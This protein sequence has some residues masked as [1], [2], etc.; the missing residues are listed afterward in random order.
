MRRFPLSDALVKPVGSRDLV[1]A[2]RHPRKAAVAAWIGSALEY[3][4]FFVYGTV[5]ALVFPRLFFPAGNPTAALF[6]SLAT[7]G[8]AYVARPLGSFLMGH[9]GDGV[10]RKKVMIWTMLLMGVA[11]FLVGCLPSYAVIGLWAPG[12]LVTLRILQGLSAAGEQAGANSMSFEHAPFGRR[13]YYTSWT[14]SGTFGGQVLAPAVVL[15]LVAVLSEDQLLT[16]GWR[17]P[18]WISA[19]IVVVGLMLRR[20]L[21]E[22]P[23][24]EEEARRGSVPRAPL[25]ELFRGHTPTVVKVF[26]AALISS[27]GTTFSVFG[28]SYATS[29]TYGNG[30]S[31]T[32]M[33][34]LAIVANVVGMV[35]IPL[36]AV[37][38]DRVGRKPV[39]IVGDVLCAAMS[40]VFI[41]AISTGN[42]PLIWVTGIL[43]GGVVYCLT[44]AVWPATYAEQFPTSVRLSGMAIGTQFGFALGGFVPLILAALVG[45]G[46]TAWIPPAAFIAAVCLVS[47]CSVATMREAF[48]TP[49]EELGGKR[50]APDVAR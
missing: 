43:M 28:L 26:F 23:V 20:T 16:W 24:F 13:G 30:V 4:D 18:F 47:A 35:V 12:L 29:A 39:F 1:T 46:S 3:Y 34:W 21:D 25:R 11:T 48:R 14:L 45:Q 5:A 36:F 8:V 37:I 49:L 50:P 38:S 9:I 44:N 19:V 40:A 31:T 10:G 7:F 17:V 15:P 2:P 42:V 27:V 32:T 41:W 22:T 6:A 33:L